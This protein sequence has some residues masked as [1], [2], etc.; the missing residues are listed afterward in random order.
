MIVLTKT[1]NILKIGFD[2]FKKISQGEP[3]WVTQGSKLVAFPNVSPD[4]GWIAFNSEGKQEDIFIAHPDGTGIRQLTDDAYKDRASRWHPDGNSIA[5]F[6]NRSGKYEIWTIHPDGSGLKQLTHYPGA[7]N[8]VWSR[9]GTK[10]A[11]SHHKPNGNFIFQ[12]RTNQVEQLPSLPDASQTFE[13]WSWSPD[14]KQLAG[15]RH[16]ENGD[17][18]GI[19][20]YSFATGK[21]DS[22][23]NFGEW[24][25]WLKDNRTILFFS[26]DRIY[27]V[28][29]Q[30]KEP[31]EIRFTP[32]QQIIGAFG[33]SPDE[34]FLYLPIDTT[35]ADV[36]LL[37]LS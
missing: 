6:S 25:I 33:I 12:P 34:N 24:P 22:L 10:I 13:A 29:Y 15:I 14:G 18:V 5:F 11:F 1:K 21:L 26:K 7:H 37:N 23:T 16:L 31:H 32:F 36:W 27:S 19:I 3:S 2:A 9:D 20:V 28:D 35:Q 17:H 30:S 4:S 8:P